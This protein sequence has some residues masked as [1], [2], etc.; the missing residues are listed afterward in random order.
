MVG[1][2]EDVEVGPEPDSASVTTVGR[3][4]PTPLRANSAAA[5]SGVRRPFSPSDDFAVGHPANC[6]TSG[7]SPPNP[8]ALWHSARFRAR[9]PC[10]WAGKWSREAGVGHPENTVS[11]PSTTSAGF[12][13]RPAENSSDRTF[14]CAVGVAQADN[15]SNSLPLGGV[16]NW[17]A[18]FR[19]QRKECV[20]IVPGTRSGFGSP[21]S[22]HCGVGQLANCAALWRFKPPSRPSEPAPVPELVSGVGQAD[23]AITI[24][25]ASLIVSDFFDPDGRTRDSGFD[26]TR[27]PLPLDASGVGLA[28]TGD[29]VQPLADVGASDEDSFPNDA[30]PT[31]NPSFAFLARARSAQIR[32]PDGVTRSFQ[33]STNSIDPGEAIL[34]RNLLAKHRCRAAL[35]DEAEEDGPQVTLVGLAFPLAGRRERLAGAAAGPDGAVVGPSGE[36]Q[37]DRPPADP[38]EEVALTVSNKVG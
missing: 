4:L 30:I 19:F 36:P 24:C 7:R 25:A 13:A 32:H 17:T 21:V 8:P 33:V 10:V 6:A 37:G 11:V 15:P 14:S 28:D 3:S 22:K 1:A 35:G 23:T 34:A 16:V 31:T 38:G 9:Y 29:P 18:S 26:D 12:G 20:G 27:P 2:G 5:P